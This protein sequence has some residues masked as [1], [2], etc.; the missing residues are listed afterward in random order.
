MEQMPQIPAELMKV[1]EKA[2]IE[3]GFDPKNPPTDSD[4][5]MWATDLI[6]KWYKVPDDIINLPL[7]GLCIAFNLTTLRKLDFFDVSNL[8]TLLATVYNMGY[9]MSQYK[10]KTPFDPKPRPQDLN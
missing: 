6:A 5:A 3:Y 10:L 9:L 1:I 8:K 2:Y 7:T 4:L